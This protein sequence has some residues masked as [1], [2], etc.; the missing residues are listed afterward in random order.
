MAI[1]TEIK[2]PVE[3]FSPILERMNNLGYSCTDWYFEQN[4][5]F[6]YEN[7]T[8][9]QKDILLRIRRGLADKITL[10][11]PAE[12]ENL[13]YKQREELESELADPGV[14]EKV[15]NCLGLQTWFRYE[16]FRRICRL[17]ET[18]VCLDILPF[19]YYVELEGTENRLYQAA[20][21]LGLEQEK[22]STKTYHELHQEYRKESGLEPDPNFV[23]SAGQKNILAQKLNV[24]L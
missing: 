21:E 1:E 24:K 3:D 9:R 10:K 15:F 11:L 23:F 4:L 7:G 5:V 18:K 16:K 19:G 14:M 6:D 13:M 22:S 12:K 20:G 8:L 17:D 2:F